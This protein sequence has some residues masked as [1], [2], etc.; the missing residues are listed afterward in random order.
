VKLSTI[1]RRIVFAF[2]RHKPWYAIRNKRTRAWYCGRIDD[3]WCFDVEFGRAEWFDD[4]DE[5]YLIV[6]WFA[7]R[8]SD[9]QLVEL[10]V[11]F[12]SNYYK[13][14]EIPW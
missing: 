4:P 3:G 2:R 14:K 11:R 6:H 7:E 13:M 1:F 12:D 8:A 9:W 10:H 5:A